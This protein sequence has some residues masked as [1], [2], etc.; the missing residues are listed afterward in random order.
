MNVLD[1][2]RSSITFRIDLDV[3]PPRT[4]SHQPPYAMNNARVQLDGRLTV[5]DRGSGRVHTFWLGVDCKTEQVGATR[6][7]WLEPNADFVPIFSDDAFMH[8][9]TFARAG[10]AR[11]AHPPATGEQTDRLTTFIVDSFVEVHVDL[12]ERDAERLTTGEAIVSAVLANDL[13]VGVH[14]LATDRYAATIEYPIKTINANERD[15]VFQTDTGPILFPDLERDPS[16]LLSGLDLAFTAANQFD[17]AEVI[18]RARTPVAEGVDVFHYARTVRL[19][20]IVNEFWRVPADAPGVP[21]RI[22][23]PRSTATAAVP[24]TV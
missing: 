8:L 15:V 2:A 19:D 17:W 14:R 11:P 21:R 23:L 16:D 7:L 22:A 3:L 13:L 20:G 5:T 18:V 1:F 6:G 12:V 9:K 4:L 10:L 24:A